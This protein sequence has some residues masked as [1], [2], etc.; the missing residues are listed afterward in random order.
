MNSVCFSHTHAPTT[1]SQS[2]EI[3]INQVW[4]LADSTLVIVMV[5]PLNCHEMHRVYRRELKVTFGNIM[6]LN[7][8]FS[9]GLQYRSCCPHL[10]DLS[11][12]TALWLLIC[13]QS[14]FVSLVLL[15]LP[16]WVSDFHCWKLTE[17]PISSIL[18]RSLDILPFHLEVNFVSATGVSVMIKTDTMMKAPFLLLKLCQL[19]ELLFLHTA[20]KSPKSVNHI[21]I[22]IASTE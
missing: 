10:Y 8:H 17:G 6:L 2:S 16:F 11:W 21:S 7:C 4:V 14:C 12:L 18:K 1:A 15:V 13:R 22:S 3:I 9:A 20:R 5:S 19:S